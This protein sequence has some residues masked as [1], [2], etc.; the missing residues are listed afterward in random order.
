MEPLDITKNICPGFGSGQVLPPVHTFP[1]E[2]PEEAFGGCIVCAAP[3]R[4]LAAHQAM[5][6]Q[7]ALILVA[8]KLGGFNRSS[9]HLDNEELRWEQASV[10]NPIVLDGHRC[11]RRSPAGGATRV[12]ATIW[13]A[14]AEGVSSEDAARTAGVS[15]PVGGRWFREGGGMPT[16]NLALLSGRYLL[17]S[18]REDIAILHAQ[19]VGIRG[20]ARR[21]GRC[22]S[23]MSREL[24]RNAATRSGDLEYRATTAQWHADRRATRPK[25]AKLPR[26]KRH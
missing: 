23:T 5:T 14:I 25:V 16:S 26:T 17:F 8:R 3:H 2:L 13:Q 4:T 19:G 24:R 12:S 6:P 10:E 9:Q 22:P 18:E 11:V 7:E 15:P 21:L 20:I 1:L